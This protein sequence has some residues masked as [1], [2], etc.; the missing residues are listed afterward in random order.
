MLIHITNA[1]LDV[2][3][4]SKVCCVLHVD[5]ATA[6]TEL[7]MVEKTRSVQRRDSLMRE[8]NEIDFFR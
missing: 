5:V 8:K 3:V 4:F 2:L 6:K 7:L 1:C